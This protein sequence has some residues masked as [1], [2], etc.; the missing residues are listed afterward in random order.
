LICSICS[1]PKSRE[2]ILPKKLAEK[3]VRHEG[4]KLLVVDVTDLPSSIVPLSSY[5]KVIVVGTKC[6]LLPRSL[7]AKVKQELSSYGQEVFLVSSVTGDGLFDLVERMKEPTNDI[8]LVG[9]PSAGKSALIN[10]L[11][12][13]SAV[14]S[15]PSLATSPVGGTT[16]GPIRIP[17][18]IFGSLIGSEHAF[19]DL[20][21][22][23]SPSQI[24]NLLSPE[25]QIAIE[26][27]GIMKPMG[28]DGFSP[29]QSFFIGGL[30]RVDYISGPSPTS[31]AFFGNHT[32]PLG[33]SSTLISDGIQKNESGYY[34]SPPSKTLSPHLG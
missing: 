18:S 4:Y 11:F 3:Y 23:V 14:H 29:G 12:R 24:S 9:T 34:L 33:M 26:K 22:I 17:F 13:L 6:D 1:S 16:A 7:H 32:I 27:Q 31:I 5:A 30:A 20:P 15:R 8:L 21:G 28:V 10:A 25:D 19:I 2:P